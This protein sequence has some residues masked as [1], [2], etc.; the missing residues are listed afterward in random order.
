[1]HVQI[2]GILF[3]TMFLR[4]ERLSR[5]A[6]L[7]SVP[8]A[9]Y[10]L[11][12]FLYCSSVYYKYH[13]V[14]SCSP[15]FILLDLPTHHARVSPLARLMYHVELHMVAIRKSLA[16][17]ELK[18]VSIVA[19]CCLIDSFVGPLYWLKFHFR[20]GKANDRKTARVALCLLL[21]G[22]LKMISNSRL[23]ST[24]KTS[25][26]FQKGEKVFLFALPQK[27]GRNPIFTSIPLIT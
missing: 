12:F 21:Y 1:M 17:W 7:L 16:D 14:K 15:S 27:A 3:F 13:S 19:F 18:A 4:I 8:T 9:F 10:S 22:R 5:K 20:H 25:L 23:H 2:G 6:E 11:V 26:F 24:V